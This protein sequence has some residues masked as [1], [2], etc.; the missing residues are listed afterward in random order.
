MNRPKPASHNE[1][2]VIKARIAQR[3]HQAMRI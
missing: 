1:N 3:S 2:G